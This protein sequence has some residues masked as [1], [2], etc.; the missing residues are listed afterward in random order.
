MQ[1][2]TFSKVAS[3]FK[4]PQNFPYLRKSCLSRHGY[5]YKYIV[6]AIELI[7]KESFKNDVGEDVLGS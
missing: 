5:D 1:V 2:R 3:P 7:V 4:E 6:T